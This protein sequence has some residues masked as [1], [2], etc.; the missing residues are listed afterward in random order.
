MTGNLIV[1]VVCTIGVRGVSNRRAALFRLR[2]RLFLEPPLAHGV[3]ES[4]EKP[5][6]LFSLR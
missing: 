5:V 4:V 1:W 2:F 6:A 3:R